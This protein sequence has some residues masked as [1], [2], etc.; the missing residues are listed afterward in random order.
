VDGVVSDGD[1]RSV[2]AAIDVRSRPEK[3]I[4]NDSIITADE[5]THTTITVDGPLSGDC[6]ETVETCCYQAVAKG[7]PVGS[8]SATF[9]Y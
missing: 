2:P 9:P 6:L 5:P 1:C 7:K 3:G 8:S 4:Y